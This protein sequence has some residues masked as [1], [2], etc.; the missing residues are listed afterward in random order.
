[1]LNVNQPFETFTQPYLL[2]PCPQRVQRTTAW[3]LSVGR[4]MQHADRLPDEE[5]SRADD[6]VRA[7]KP[8]SKPLT[9]L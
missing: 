8:Y 5:Q 9:M 7:A 3:R 4:H 6:D 1:M 2:C